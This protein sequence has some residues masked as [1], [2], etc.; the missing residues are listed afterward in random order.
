MNPNNPRIMLPSGA[1]LSLVQEYFKWREVGH[2]PAEAWESAC[3][4]F[5]YF[6]TVYGAYLV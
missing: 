4:I 3:F 1:T 5:K 6:E 2:K